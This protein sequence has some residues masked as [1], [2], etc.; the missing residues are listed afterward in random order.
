MF[1][2]L[3]LLSLLI[4]LPVVGGALVL[5][6]S[7]ADQDAH[8]IRYL[9]LAISMLCM[10]LCVPLYTQFDMHTYLMQFH[11]HLVWIPM[12]HINYDLGV[13]GISMPLVIL[14]TYTTLLVVL[15]SWRMVKTKV[16]QYLATFLIMQGMVVGIFCALDSILFYVFWEA[17]LIPMY[18]SIGI[19]GGANRSYAAVKFFL[20]TFFGSALLLIAL[21]YL[22]IKAG[23]FSVLGFYPLQLSSVEQIFIFL[24]FLL[25]F[26]IKVPMCPAHTWLPDAHTEAPAGGSVI[27]A[28]LMLKI[29]AYGFLRFSLPITPDACQS[30]SWFMIALSLL[31]II[32]IGFIALS[33]TDMKRLI[34]YSSVA[35][36]GFVT[37]GCFMIFM[38]VKHA[39]NIQ[40]AYM[41]LD[42]AIVQMVSHAFGSGAMFIG[43][44]MLYERMH[45]RQIKDFG[46]IAHTMPVFAA[47]FM[48]F[49]MSNVG[50][51][52][53]SGFV[54]EFLIILSAFKASFWIAFLAAMTLV[55]SAS[56]TL[57]MY[58]RVFYGPI[59]N[60]A[61]SKLHD[62]DALEKLILLLLAAA[63]FWFGLYPQSLLNVLHA[64][65][66][67]LLDLAVKT[68]LV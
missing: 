44:G 65:V 64:S 56:Y 45:T 27:L 23:D 13:D 8:W 48:V 34:A 51:P 22:G 35:H 32:Y 4:W 47:L 68:K 63:V 29:G 16:A 15:A 25:A 7:K 67:H 50:L 1:V 62:I 58:K 11:E 24:A 49:A 55:I 20:Y 40:D 6:V 21:L 9:A 2:H 41:S 42:G 18:L 54:G 14:T 43:F 19:W 39:G 3:P 36:M 59:N 61:V 53:T 28:A 52:G 31:A 46:G 60:D 12:Y 5:A 17:V 37:L 57:W 66:G 38:L 30:L 33:Q 26:A 10:V